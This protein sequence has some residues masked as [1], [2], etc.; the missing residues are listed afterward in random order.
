MKPPAPDVRSH[1][2]RGALEIQLP[3]VFDAPTGRSL[4]CLDLDSRQYVYILIIE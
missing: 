2:C 4:M 1:R 3:V